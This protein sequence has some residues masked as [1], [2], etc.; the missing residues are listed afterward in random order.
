MKKEKLYISTIAD[1]AAETAKRYGLGL[2]IAEF[3]TAYNMDDH[4]N[5]VK[6][7]VDRAF[8]SAERFVFHASFNELY[9]SA[10]DPKAV[11]LAHF[12]LNQAWKLAS[13]FGITKMIV[14]SGNV[15]QLYFKSWY[16]ERSVLFWRDFLRD[17]PLNIELCM[18][19]VLEDEPEL[20]YRVVEAVNDPRFR[21]CLDIGH[22]NVQ[23]KI[24]P[25]LWLEN[26]APLISHFHIHNNTGEFDMHNGLGDGAIEMKDFLAHAGALCPDAT[27]TIETLHAEPSVLWLRDNG[28]LT[29]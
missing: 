29:L 4:Y 1:D 7:A 20:L 5:E 16:E 19:N 3:C 9:P 17:K 26:D 24:S 28:F 14:H 23:S 22:A 11:E 15:P 13:S 25:I 12:R 10:I 18:E 21:L 6:P 27:Y 2:E 8:A